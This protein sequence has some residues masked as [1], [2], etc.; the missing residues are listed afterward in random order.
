MKKNFSSE[1]IELIKTHQETFKA[2]TKLT[3]QSKV[4][5]FKHIDSAA[6]DFQV[7]ESQEFVS[8]II[9][10]DEVAH[11][12][13]E[14]VIGDGEAAEDEDSKMNVLP[15]TA[16]TMM[17][18]IFKAVSQHLKV[19]CS[20]EDYKHK[21]SRK[22]GKCKLVDWTSNPLIAY[23]VYIVENCK[24]FGGKQL[25]NILQILHS[26]ESHSWAEFFDTVPKNL[27]TL[28]VKSPVNEHNCVTLAYYIDNPLNHSDVHPKISK[29]KKIDGKASKQKYIPHWISKVSIA[30]D[31][32]LNARNFNKQLY[33]ANG[34]RRKAENLIQTQLLLDDIA[35]VDGNVYH[36]F[37]SELHLSTTI[38][39][40]FMFGHLTF[41]PRE[42]C[43]Q[44]PIV[45]YVG[46]VLK[47]FNKHS[48]RTDVL[49]VQLLV[50]NRSVEVDNCSNKPVFLGQKFKKMNTARHTV[51]E[52]EDDNSWSSRSLDLIKSNDGSLYPVVLAEGLQLFL[53]IPSVDEYYAVF[54]GSNCPGDRTRWT[55]TS[56]CDQFIYNDC[57]L[58]FDNGTQINSA[59]TRPDYP[60]QCDTIRW[61]TIHFKDSANVPQPV[62]SNFKWAR[63]Y[64]EVFRG[65][66]SAL[67]PEASFIRAKYASIWKD[68]YEPHDTSNYNEGTSIYAYR[69]NDEP[70]NRPQVFGMKFS[71]AGG[72]LM[73][74]AIEHEFLS[75]IN[76]GIV[77]K[78]YDVNS[79]VLKPEWQ[80]CYPYGLCGDRPA[81]QKFL[82]EVGANGKHSNPRI[83]G[84]KC[85]L[86][87]DGKHPHYSS[88]YLPH[89]GMIKT[90]GFH[91]CLHVALDQTPQ[92]SHC[93]FICTSAAIAHYYKK[94]SPLTLLL[95]RRLMFRADGFHCI[96]GGVYKDIAKSLHSIETAQDPLMV[97]LF[98]KLYDSGTTVAPY[99]YRA[100][101]SC[102]LKTKIPNKFNM[103]YNATYMMMEMQPLLSVQPQF[104]H[105]TQDSVYIRCIRDFWLALNFW[106]C[107]SGRMH[108]PCANSRQFQCN[109]IQ[110]VYVRFMNKLHQIIAVL[111]NEI[112]YIKQSYLNSVDQADDKMNIVNVNNQV[113]L[114]YS[115]NNPYVCQSSPELESV[116]DISDDGEENDVVI[117]EIKN[118]VDTDMESDAIYVPSVHSTDSECNEVLEHDSDYD[119]E[120]NFK[121]NGEHDDNVQMS[122]ADANKVA[123]YEN[124]IGEINSIVSKPNVYLLMEML[125]IDGYCSPM[126]AGDC[127]NFEQGLRETKASFKKSDKRFDEVKNVTQMRNIKKT[128]IWSDYWAKGNNSMTV[129]QQEFFCQFLSLPIRSCMLSYIM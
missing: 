114:V 19:P 120:Q 44:F 117:T 119:N 6:P 70:N 62:L 110:T 29:K 78:R 112:D 46:G 82:V 122:E 15:D 72:K 25:S 116:V 54:D 126:M 32:K 98:S 21:M 79:G 10:S 95:N 34:R 86:S 99:Q 57:H 39:T 65:S 107:L 30:D 89:C 20:A 96:F 123:K 5:L 36:A 127:A 106:V 101:I 13:N 68:D 115:K 49:L 52:M 88:G 92:S 118:N 74:Q 90:H 125:G 87:V 75:Y 53:K 1:E 9:D 103:I 7:F 124:L 69:M 73:W 24:G 91:E 22:L 38:P 64:R 16:H 11:M 28:C 77:V 67:A 47:R 85:D 35:Q 100:P 129:Q 18:R 121:D 109:Y 113:N 48:K 31:I 3:W 4:H 105:Q 45:S 97:E 61:N 66:K 17:N 60:H 58:S 40:I 84:L 12:V 59:V 83:V 111:K 50:Q 63:T 128:R 51:V 23:C 94:V 56:D 104:I 37:P 108:S 93:K 33:L 76:A 80:V 14:Q 81:A 41:V 71:H 27:A 8:K 42:L 43:P 26:I 55:L 102:F 2:W